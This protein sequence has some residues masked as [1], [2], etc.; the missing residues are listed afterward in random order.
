M[1]E[2][3]GV[4]GSGL[5]G[6]G[7]AQVAAQNGFDVTLLEVNEELLVA[8]RSRIEKWLGKAVEK[9]KLSTAEMTATLG[10][11][12]G[13]TRFEDLADSDIVIEAITEKLQ[14]KLDLFTKLNS[15]CQSKCLFASNTSSLPITEM[16]AGSG[17]PDRFL[18]LHFFNPVPVMQLVE[19]IRSPATGTDAIDAAREFGEKLGKTVIATEDTPGFV[20]NRLL[21]PYLLDAIRAL[22][23]GVASEAEI[24][25]GMTLGCGHP[26]GPLALADFVGLDTLRHISEVLFAAF[27]DPRYAAPPLLTRMVQAGYLGRKSGKGFFDYSG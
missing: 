15:V 25:A 10:R 4:A 16:G 7:I 11:I 21:T 18:G 3:V 9:G 19:L 17:R 5:M 13:T 2:R 14:A 26:M 8:G 1:I 27:K 24:D 6:A 20:V 12:T 22:E 23:A